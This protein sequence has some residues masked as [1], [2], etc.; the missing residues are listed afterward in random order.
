MCSLFNQIFVLFFGL[1]SFQFCFSTPMS[2][3]STVESHSNYLQYSHGIG[4]IWKMILLND[5]RITL[6]YGHHMKRTGTFRKTFHLTCLPHRL[7]CLSQILLYSQIVISIQIVQL[8]GSKRNHFEYSLRDILF[9]FSFYF[10]IPLVGFVWLI[11]QICVKL[12]HLLPLLAAFR[13][14][15]HRKTA[16]KKSNLTS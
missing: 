12:N 5:L 4:L 16:K 6:V 9:Y 1:F 8:F 3:S 7:V 13:A 15:R 10:S 2:T 11:S 14:L